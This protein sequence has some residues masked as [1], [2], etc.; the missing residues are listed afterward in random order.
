VT[1]FIQNDYYMIVYCGTSNYTTC[2]SWH[3]CTWPHKFSDR[4]TSWTPV[5]CH[6][7]TP[8]QLP[9][10]KW[11]SFPFELW[12]SSKN[13]AYKVWTSWPST[14]LP[15]HLISYLICM[16]EGFLLL[17]WQLWCFDDRIS[18]D[19]RVALEPKPKYPPPLCTIY[20]VSTLRQF[21]N[22]RA[23]TRSLFSSQWQ[24]TYKNWQFWV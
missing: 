21:I 7:Q 19:L 14:L 2:L 13:V 22:D 3:T 24:P 11:W 5:K 6:P 23:E 9:R 15:G 4:S 17:E 12:Q 8:T 20:F 1:W 10:T 18:L 16:H